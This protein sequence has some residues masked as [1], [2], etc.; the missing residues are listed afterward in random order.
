MLEVRLLGQFA[1]QLD[2]APV[3]LNAR[4]AQSLLAYLLLNPVAHRRE[5]L[6]GLLW[7]D[8]SEANARRNLRQAL[9]Q[10]RRALED[11]A[12]TL[13]LVD[14]ITLAFNTDSDYW[15]DAATVARPLDDAVT[16]DELIQ[17]VSVY[18]G[19]L[20]PG[21]YDEWVQLERER[22]QA[23][24]ERAFN[25]LLARLV[26]AQRWTDVLQW[27]ERWIA[28]GYTPEPAY[29]ALMLAHA[30]LGDMASVA[31]LYRRC[32][33]ALERDLGVEPSAQTHALY[34]RLRAGEGVPLSQPTPA[35]T[36]APADRPNHNLPVALTTF[37]GRDKEMAA[38]RRLLLPKP[39]HGHTKGV[40]LLTL[41]GPGGT[42]KT[43]L[44]LQAA[45]QLRD[46]FP[47]GV[48]LVELAMLA[49]PVLI[50][51]TVAALLGV[52]EEPNYPLT[53]ALTDHLRTQTL[54]LIFDDC[55][56]LV[57]PCA[58]LVETLLHA[59]PT[60]KI[61]VTSRET[62]GVMGEQT[63]RVPSL[64]LP[65]LHQSLPLADLAQCEAIRLFI[66]RSVAVKPAF[67]LTEANAGAVTQICRQLD[68]VPLAIELAAARV[69]TMTPEQIA[70][71]LDD[72]FRLLTGGSRTALPRQQ[73]LRA[74]I[75]WSWDLL[76]EAE[77]TLL[78]RLA[79]FSGGWTLEAAE[80][81]CGNLRITN[82]DLRV[83][84]DDL[85]DADR[86]QSVNRKSEI[87]KPEDV[88][89]LLTHLVEKSLV[90]VEE[91]AGAARYYLLETLRQYARQKL[92][93]AGEAEN[94]RARHLAFFLQL[95]EEAE[96]HLR[97]AAQLSWLARLDLEHDN[98]RA[99]L[100]WAKGS[101]AL[102]AGLRLAGSL[103]RFWYLRGFWQEGREWLKG[104]LAQ[105]VESTPTFAFHAPE[106][107][108]EQALP[109]KA[110]AAPLLPATLARARAR[111]LAGA[112][113]LADADGSEIPLYAES[114]PL[115][116][117]VG[118]R[119]G[120]AYALRGLVVNSS[121]LTDL[122]QA[123]A[124]LQESLT[125]F[126]ALP[127]PWGMG[128]ATFNLGWIA[129]NRD[130]VD[131]AAATW[132]E[133]LRHFRTCGDRW[134]ISVTLGGLGYLARLH[135]H[136]PQAASLIQESLE[137]FR[138]LGDRAGVSYS[139]VRLGNLAWRRGDYTEAMALLQES[140][141]VQRDRNNQEGIISALQLQGLVA[142]YQGNFAQATA[143]LHESANLAQERAI[144]AEMGD[145]LRFQAWVCYASNELER[146]HTLF[147]ES[148]ALFQQEN[149]TDG[150]AF[151]CY[152]LGLIAL[153]CADYTLATTHLQ[154][155]LRLWRQ[156]GD[157]HYIAA[158]LS[159]LGRLALAQKASQDATDHFC[160][161]LALYQ[162][163]VD[164]QGA[165][166]ALEGF[167][168]CVSTPAVAVQL[169]GAAQAL[170]QAIGAPVPPVAQ[171]E[172]EQWLAKV[173]TT[174]DEPTFAKC[175]A[176]G[177]ALSY[178]QAITLA[179]RKP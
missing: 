60:L 150:L 33:D 41:T 138:E 6:A 101:G 162:E 149:D 79:V 57:E 135:G 110:D 11:Q 127:D 99:A 52:R 49:D 132:E 155:S 50:P 82:Y 40:R 83:T 139:L 32:V 106:Q 61:I 173:R 67:A 18:S 80:A 122:A 25:L 77:Y 64:Q 98:L 178:E 55:E 161:S 116:R 117:Q 129:M 42:G 75:D 111:A 2:G 70:A 133:A 112:G 31:D 39:D 94:V 109:P 136:Y 13:L 37:I 23:H 88:L 123:E 89:E 58:Q 20:L 148:L 176:E 134:G 121:N 84:S 160:A 22:L 66:D 86:A 167:A 140:L 169:F 105:P 34:E 172:Y 165:A 130:K 51:Q 16:A 26:A 97:A 30:G 126:R 76:S 119:W 96:P 157:R 163:M 38:I 8:S 131:D 17:I 104:L 5:R 14:E 137:L 103:A 15:L 145:N 28:L 146:A 43:R 78:R 7:P 102:E 152:G 107:A 175:W 73:T 45:M 3:E 35:P 62:L 177:G 21:F 59:C 19:E 71:R 153:Q 87:V 92:L 154:E 53:R 29:R 142:C 164:K 144:P 118:D 120:E 4:P 68:G 93:E 168:S 143:W 27:G 74:M 36:P 90:V 114:L 46:A 115:C 44:A 72:R 9:W 170:R 91:Q 171:A 24:Y 81:V 174:I 54:L 108:A 113:W 125:I 10:L 128:L 100:Q 63:L 12:D 48:W 159:S 69:R 166:G 179:L 1:L 141:Q 156:R 65:D 47:D 151:S 147:S 124:Y 85:R 95:A 56:H 158:V